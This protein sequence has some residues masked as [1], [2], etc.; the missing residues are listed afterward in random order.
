[1]GDV[2]NQDVGELLSLVLPASVFGPLLLY[3]YWRGDSSA[4]RIAIC[5]VL[6]IGALFVFGVGM[7]MVDRVAVLADWKQL[8][9]HIEDGGEMAVLSGLAAYVMSCIWVGPRAEGAAG[10]EG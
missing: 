1:M 2:R 8:L 10:R 3:G 7:D 4:R 6:F 5:V 9:V